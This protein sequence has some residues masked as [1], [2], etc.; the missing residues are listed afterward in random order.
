MYNKESKKVI[1][2]T[3]FGAILELY[4]FILY[5][6]FSK[7]ITNTFFTEI[8]N[9]QIQI[10]LTIS[11]FSIAYIVRPFAGIILGMV[12]DIIGRRKLLLF[13][14]S[15]MGIC[16]L[17]IGLMPGYTYL[18]LS[19]SF[20]IIFLRILQGFALGGELPGACVLLHESVKGKIGFAS[21]MLFTFVTASFLLCGLITYLLEMVFHEYAWRIGFI[22]GGLLSFV[23]YYIRKSLNES[24]EFENINKQEKHSFKSLI[25]TYG[26]NI[27]GGISIV[28]TV[29]FSG[30]MLTLYTR[31]FVE[32]LLPGYDPA[33]ISLLL[34]P[35]LLTLTVSTFVFGYFSDKVG[36]AKTFTLGALSTA[37]MST[38][39]YYI[40]SAFHTP[41]VIAISLMVI[42]LSGGLV[43]ASFIFLLCDLFPTD[44][45]LSGVGISYNLAFAIVGGIGPLASTIIIA[46]TKYYFLGPA[47]VGGVCGMVGLLGVLIYYKKGGYHKSNPNLIV[48]L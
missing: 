48:K 35:A 29:A 24:S 1:M 14:I 41:Y 32:G 45:R 27:L 11:I 19:A 5:M 20:I 17:G 25:S 13:T 3:G 34:T 6:T 12:G 30:I 26:L 39:I 43:T 40:M 23:G 38:P 22:L 46:T 37:I 9:P 8:T 16:S 28:I 36:I 7:E 2:L 10:F 44:I 4:D 33:S 47:I 15:L 31:K 18:G 42:M 21:A